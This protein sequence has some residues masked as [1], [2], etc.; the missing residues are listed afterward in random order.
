MGALQWRFGVWGRLTKIDPEAEP[1][2]QAAFGEN[3]SQNRTHYRGHHKHGRDEGDEERYF[4][5]RD[6][7]ASYDQAAGK[8]P[9]C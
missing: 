6:D 9:S 8:D 2:G 1:P 5:L 4:L 3:T 7:I